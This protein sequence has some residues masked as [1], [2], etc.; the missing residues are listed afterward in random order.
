MEAVVR[1]IQKLDA[2]VL[3]LQEVEAPVY[4]RL[5]LE[6][7]PMGYQGRFLS[8]EPG[9]SDG[10]ATLVRGVDEPGWHE[11]RFSDGGPG[12]P[13]SGHVALTLE[14]PLGGRRLAVANTHLKWDPPG[15][16]VASQWAAR[17]MAELIGF[18]KALGSEGTVVAGDFN[19]VSR[20]DVVRQL[21]Q[22]GFKEAFDGERDS[23]FTV[24]TGKKPRKIDYL[25]YSPKLRARPHP[26]GH[27]RPETV[28]PCEEEP[29][30]HIPLV[31]EIEWLVSGR[32]KKL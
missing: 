7:E 14:F 30:D 11:L 25:F 15:V 17:Q 23:V 8:R 12:Q 22:A 13:N 4:E 26:M 29:S 31:V 16:T 1:R 24:V 19:V 20:D 3:C 18:L 28:L 6:L 27:L 5:T 9:N 2:D 21:R 32:Q 10:C